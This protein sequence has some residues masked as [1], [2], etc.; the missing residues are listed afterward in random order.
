MV[1]K[2]KLKKRKKISACTSMYI[3]TITHKTIINLTYN[4]IVILVLVFNIINK[5]VVRIC[6]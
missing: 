2:N 3:L 5:T 4:F 6:I 1:R